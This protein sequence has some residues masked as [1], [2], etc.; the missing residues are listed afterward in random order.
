MASLARRDLLP[1]TDLPKGSDLLAEGRALA[2][3]WRV[4]PSAF[5]RDRA[6]ASELDYKRRCMTEGRVMQHA[7]IG[8]RTLEESRR[9]YGEIWRR[10]AA[11]GVVV[12]RY[13]LCLDWSMALPRALRAKAQRGTGM[14][15]D[16][17]EDFV[18][19]TESAPVAPHFGDFVLGFPAAVENTAAALVAGSTAIGNLG[20]YFTFRIPNHDDDVAATRETVRALG[21]IAAQPVPV[22]VHSNIDDG[23]AARFTDLASCL[24]F[25]SIE[26]DLVGRLVGAPIG[27]CYGHHFSDPL[28]RLAF[29]RALVRIG[30]TPGTVVYGNTTSYR[31]TADENR[32][33]LASYLL[34]DALAQ[35]LAPSG[36]AINAVP[37][38]ENERIPDV[39]EVV[40]AQLFA[41][42]LAE[43]AAGHV[44]LV[45]LT[46]V[47][48][49][50]DR[51]LDGA[52]RFRTRVN[53][54]LA[55]AGIDTDDVFEMLLALRRLGAGPLER[56]FGAGAE[57]AAA[58]GGRRP[59]AAATIVEEID[60]MA[61][62]ALATVAEPT[63]ARVRHRRPRLLVASGDVHEHGKMVIEAIAG[64]LGLP[65]DDGGVSTD[66]AV[67][68]DLVARL[69]PDAVVLGTYNGVA[70]AYFEELSRRLADRGLRVPVLIG[71]RLNQ[72]PEGSNTSLPV[73]VGDRLAAAG[74]VVCRTLADVVP[75]LATLAET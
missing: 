71:G 16:D 2:G 68:A 41:G 40:E 73:D 15:L 67:L 54:G 46:L 20:Q 74:A 26:R 36:H 66:P 4:G 34:I 53:A 57:D 21:L 3:D 13:G 37:V 38:T 51:L 11:R 10:C 47:D 50:A 48:A 5:L 27:H 33:G 31:G 75:A 69:R 62:A 17:V 6:V 61:G 59:V 14:I 1:E 64:R 42:R 39:D 22:L 45:D 49:F 63:I 35:R 18:R 23:Y 52:E 72:I 58:P 29:Q 25:V 30:A 56:L 70:L 43:H 44:P 19:L 24:G 28:A 9:A 65:V 8:F 32:A 7:Q 60:D 55:A 12:D